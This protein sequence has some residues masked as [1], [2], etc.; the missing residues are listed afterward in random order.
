MHV[1]S[2]WSIYTDTG[3]G[4]VSGSIWL[5]GVPAGRRFFFVVAAAA[6]VQVAICSERNGSGVASSGGGPAAGAQNPNMGDARGDLGEEQL[7]NK[8]KSQKNLL[9]FPYY[10]WSG[11]VV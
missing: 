8:K 10:L 3:D 6:A 7:W 1:A 9:L 4:C 5:P 11:L 2:N